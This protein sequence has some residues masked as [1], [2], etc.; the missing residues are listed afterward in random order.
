MSLAPFTNLAVLPRLRQLADPTATQ[1]ALLKSITQNLTGSPVARALGLRG[2]ESFDEYRSI[3]PRDYSFYA[4]LVRRVL[5][6]DAHAFG[7]RPVIALG[8]TSGTTGEPKL[9]PYNDASLD[10]LRRFIRLVLLFQLRQGRT[11]LPRFTKWLLVTASSNVR[12][13]GQIPVGFVSGLVHYKT[14]QK[15]QGF[16]LPSPEV[17][18]VGDWDERIRRSAAEALKSRVGTLFGVPAYLARFLKEASRQAGGQMLG[19]VWPHLDEVYYSGTALGAHLGEIESLTGRNVIAR[20]LYMSTEGIFGAE[21]DWNAGGQ[22]RLLPDMN[23]MMFR[24]ADEE[25]AGGKLRAMWELERGRRYELI[26]TTP[27]GLCQYGMK[28]VLEVTQTNPL[29]VRLAG[30]VG[31]EINL[32]TE[33]LSASQAEKTMIE[34]SRR[35][36]V[37]PHKFVVLP[38]PTNARRHLWF[39]E[40]E[41]TTEAIDTAHVA[42]TIDEELARINPSYAALRAND[43]VLLSPR[44]VVLPCGAFDS[45]AQAGFAKRGQFKF[46]HVFASGERLRETAGMGI[47]VAHLD[48]EEIH[49]PAKRR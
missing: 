44:A 13:A 30:R 2:D 29:L 24:D 9:I 25:T 5:D 46:R 28:D 17:A 7:R 39:T 34:T 49:V 4:P 14:Q 32:A 21:L 31:D 6:G 16:I 27:S 10:T 19:E 42:Q 37:S 11:F 26:I 18:A 22:I 36:P 47:C 1:R 48:E 20:S 3:E 15:R 38:D 8:E 35:S 12:F 43:A 45:Y 33:K 23:V 41:E 40:R